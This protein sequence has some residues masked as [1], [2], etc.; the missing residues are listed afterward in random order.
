MGQTARRWLAGLGTAAAV[1]VAVLGPVGVAGAAGTR[2]AARTRP[3]GGQV[4][5]GQ[6]GRAF[7]ARYLLPGAVY[8]P[9]GRTLR[10][11]E[12]GPAVR[13]LQQ[14]LNFL[15]Y[16]PG[17]VNGYFGW[18]T[19]EAVWAFKEVQSGRRIPARRTS[20]AR[21]CGRNC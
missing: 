3:A 20:P 4:S 16:Y 6:V 9:A 8:V 2:P 21:R 12:H 5:S 19:L 11:G 1:G 18:D 14:R 10:L 15:H 13:A 7:L 17:S